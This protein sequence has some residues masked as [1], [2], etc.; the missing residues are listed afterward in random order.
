MLRR[1][2]FQKMLDDA[3]TEHPEALASSRPTDRFH[4]GAMG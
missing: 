4:Q 2:I 3:M 1:E